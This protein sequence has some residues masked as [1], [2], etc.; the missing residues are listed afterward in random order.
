MSKGKYTKEF[1]LK[2]VSNDRNETFLRIGSYYQQM[3]DSLI[4]DADAPYREIAL[5]MN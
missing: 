3:A 5:Q 2:A 1:K 4:Y